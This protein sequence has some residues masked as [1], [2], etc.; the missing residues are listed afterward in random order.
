MILIGELALWVALLMSAWTTIVSFAGGLQ[1]RDD[2]IVSGYRG[3]YASFA[4][5]AIRLATP[6]L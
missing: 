3:M 4:I 2:L 6:G 5:I 1:R